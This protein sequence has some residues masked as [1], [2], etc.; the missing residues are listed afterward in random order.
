[1]AA[2]LPDVAVVKQP[3]TGNTHDFALGVVE[4]VG[5]IHILPHISDKSRRSAGLFACNLMRFPVCNPL[6]VETIL[7][8]PRSEGRGGG[9]AQTPYI[10]G[11]RGQGLVTHVL[12][13]LQ[14]KGPGAE[15]HTLI[16]KPLV[17]LM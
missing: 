12:T 8:T 10:K 15:A 9:P 6:R 7:V 2:M 11:P 14:Y 4:P 3:D 1:M 17:F 13:H 16:G 5:E